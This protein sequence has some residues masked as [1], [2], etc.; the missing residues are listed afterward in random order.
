[1]N[2]VLPKEL[3]YVPSLPSLPEC[4][5]QEVVLAPVNGGS[6]GPSSLIQFDLVARG[7]IDPASIYL[8]YKATLTNTSTQNSTM[9][10]TPVYSFFNKLETIF[11]S[12]VVESVNQYNQVCNMMTNLQLSVAQKYGQQINY[13]WSI[14]SSA[15]LTPSLEQLDGRICYN[16]EVFTLAAPLPCILSMAE[17]LIPAGLMPNIRI[18]LTTA[19][20]AEAFVNANLPTAYSLTN[21][22]LCYTMVDFSGDTNELVKNMGD[23]F[24]I[25]STSFKNMGASLSSGVSGSIDLVYNMRLASIKSLF[26]HFC[27]QN[28][29]ACVNGIFDSIDPTS[30]NGELVYNIAGTSYPTR[31]VSTLNNKAAVM[32]ELKKAVGALHSTE[33]NTS[34]NSVEFSHTDYSVLSTEVIAG[35]AR[36]PVPTQLYTAGKFIFSCNTEKFSTSNT[37]L[38]GIS[39]Q[40]SPISLRIS[41]NTATLQAYNVYLMAMYDCLI[42]VNPHERNAS[43]KE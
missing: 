43:V 1:M 39:T 34:I 24:Y 37:I 17:K 2:V 10:G 26:A 20:I 8:R 4:L 13:G 15:S 41:T 18:Q 27:G 29:T 6:F 11:G 21:V 14:G 42:Q 40:S 28:A 22:E 33:Y 5:S 36:V 12:S 31:P 25:K 19:S 23:Q 38:S 16:N 7:F 32:C 30:G 9:K 3:A 35:T